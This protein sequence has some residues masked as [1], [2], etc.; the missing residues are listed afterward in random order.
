[1]NLIQREQYY[2][3]VIMSL[4][5][6]GDILG[7]FRASFMSL[8]NIDKFCVNL[9]KKKISNIEM[10]VCDLKYAFS[11]IFLPISIFCE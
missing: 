2:Y 10:S 11:T 5:E 8:L 4:T 3:E 9:Q 7:P 6:F 1:M